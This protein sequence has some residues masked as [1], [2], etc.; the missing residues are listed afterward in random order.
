MRVLVADDEDKLR[1]TI[2]DYFV[3]KGAAVDLAKN[4]REAVELAYSHSYDIIILDVMMP[5]MDGIA[6]CREIRENLDVPT[7]FLTDRK[8]VV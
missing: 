3:F 5:V 4:G 7:I 8:S 1:E 2:Y 6:A